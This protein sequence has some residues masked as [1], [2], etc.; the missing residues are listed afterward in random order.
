VSANLDLVRSIYVIWDRGESALSLM[1]ERVVWDFSRRQIEPEVY[2]GHEAVRS[3]RR[4]LLEAWSELR[5]APSDFV[6]AG[7]R[8]LV[9]L[10]FG[11]KGRSSGV[12]VAERIAH[13]W[14][15][16]DGKVVS[17]EYFGDVAEGRAALA[18]LGLEA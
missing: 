18:D 6:S 9:L 11:G 14:T 8:V 5:Y 10:T 7:E 2:H 3:F 4:T 13:L 1:D 16:R 15:L 12:E 17:L